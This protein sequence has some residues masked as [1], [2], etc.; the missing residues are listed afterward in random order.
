MSVED[1]IFTG[2]A[3]CQGYAETYKAIARRAGLECELVSGHGKGYGHSPLKPG[4]QPPPPNPTGHAWN[5]VRIDGGVW[6]LI[7]ACWGAGHLGDD[8]QYKQKFDPTEFTMPN[9]KFSWK[10]FPRD[11]KYQHRD[12]G[13][14]MSWEEYFIGPFKGEPPIVFGTAKE[15]GILE[16]SIEPKIRQIQVYSGEIV[17]FQFS[18]ICEHWRSETHGK[19]KPPLL[20]LEI[21]GLDGRKDEMV[22]METDGYWHWVDVNARDLGAPGQSVQVA[23]ITSVQ[24]KD[25]RGISAREFL[26]KKGKVGMAWTYVMKWELV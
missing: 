22:P 15:E 5:A 9:D 2:K 24:D 4:E 19:G 7:D 20:L 26:S 6:K 21:H 23:Q 12:D 11:S 14:I 17:R 13:R 8:N 10:H 18:K 25:A 16:E 3:V 1:T